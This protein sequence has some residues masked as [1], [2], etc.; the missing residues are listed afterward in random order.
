MKEK[1]T[2]IELFSGIGAQIQ[3]IK[4]TDLFDVES[5]GVS[6]ID[7]NAVIS[8][9]AV[10]CGLTSELLEATEYPSKEDMIAYLT[11]RNIGFVFEENK[12]C[13]WGS[14]SIAF[15]RKCW[16]ACKLSN[17]F[18]DIQKVSELPYADFWTYS[19]PCTDLSRAGKQQGMIKG[20]TRSG[21]LYEVE[22]LLEK[23]VEQGTQPKYL[24]LENVKA[25]VDKQ[26]YMQFKEWEMRLDEL[27]Y[28]TYLGIMNAKDFGVLQNR[29][30][31]FAI[32]IRKDIDTR[33]YLFPV[34][35]D[36]GETL[37]D[38]LEETVDA[39]YKVSDV[40]KAH[41]NQ[42]L[43]DGL[44]ILK[45]PRGVHKAT[46]TEV[47]PTITT[48]SWSYNTAICEG[49]ELRRLTPKECWRFM[50]FPDS[51]VEAAMSVGMSDT[52]LYAQAGNSI[53]VGCIRLMIEHLYKAQY[54]DSYIC[55]DEN[56]N[57]ATTVVNP[58]CCGKKKVFCIIDD[59]YNSRE[60][61]ISTEYCPTLRAGRFGLK[62]LTLSQLHSETERN[63]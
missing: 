27:G 43:A 33:S 56:F 17:N 22:R 18:G 39:K 29:E 2:L 6:E 63:E 23:A 11:E 34:P 16:L 51:A 19:F 61:R 52:S 13:N 4:D 38:Y 50:G 60:P 9:A 32:S 62:V 1:L 42:E 58:D 44:C 47:C 53:V 35:F 54:D 45:R 24:M 36:K 49:D 5:V 15:L 12:P 40:A 3:G 37:Q 41:F 14:A 10:H 57:K 28:N 30:R 46:A 21:L 59:I 7:S 48:S 20:K 31:A 55:S 25:L 26:F 8:Y